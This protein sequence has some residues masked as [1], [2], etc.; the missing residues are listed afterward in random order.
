VECPNCG[1]F[2]D[3]SSGRDYVTCEYCRSK[4]AVLSYAEELIS[5]IDLTEISKDKQKW[6]KNMLAMAS[7]DMENRNYGDAYTTYE[8]ILVDQPFIWEAILNEAICIFWLG[9]QDMQH[10]PRVVTLLQKADKLSDRNALVQKAREDI[11]HNLA[12][13]ASKKERY[14]SNIRWSMDCFNIS[15][16]L[17]SHDKERDQL[18]AGYAVACDNEIFDR[19]HRNLERDKKN[20]DPPKSDIETLCE[21][22]VLTEGKEEKVLQNAIMFA[23][24][25]LSRSGDKSDLGR[26]LDELKSLHD[27]N[28]RGKSVYQIHFPVMG[29]PKIVEVGD[30]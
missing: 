17:V 16:K 15:K 1:K 21:L 22:A 2:L 3:T 9:R 6:I 13:L 10:M 25:K 12:V 19:L 27:A 30:R 18:I 23:G 11:A 7:I 24:Y 14:G 8:K 28:Y 5:S 29:G 26:Y 20:F 4:I